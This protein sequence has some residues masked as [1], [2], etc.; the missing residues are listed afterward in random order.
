M[1]QVFA[2]AGLKTLITRET[3]RNGGQIKLYFINGAIIVLLASAVSMLGLIIFVR[4]VGYSRDTAAV[5]MLVSLGIPTY[6]LTVICDA[7]FQATGRIHLSAVAQLPFHIAKVGVATLLLSRGYGLKA[8]I[9][10]LVVS[11]LA[12]LLVEC[13]LLFRHTKIASL[14]YSAGFAL[15]LARAASTFLWIDVLVA[16][17]AGYNVILLSIFATEREV[18][19]YSAAGQLLIPVKLCYLAIA[20]SVFPMMCRSHDLGTSELKLVANRLI[21][22]LLAVVVPTAV[23]LFFL[24]A[25]ALTL[26]YGSRDFGAATPAFQV[27]VWMLIPGAVTSALGY[28]LWAS[29]R[30]SLTLRIVAVGT[31][32]TFVAGFVLVGHFG[33]VGAAI[34]GAIVSIVDLMQHYFYVRR[35]VYRV[36]IHALGWKPV[37]AGLVMALYLSAVHQASPLANGL[38][39]VTT[40]TVALIVLTL[41]SL[42]MSNRVASRNFWL[43]SP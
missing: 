12:I 6:A 39:A 24:A 10:V 28:L 33:V 27:M 20:F 26:L 2:G 1:C 4:V 8:I 18:G 16:L 35:A 22:F 23:A 34:A 21:A 25:P 32:V 29:L 42:A 36:R 19:L 15:S 30:E 43:S 13:W 31:A 11:Q 3:A 14:K 37:V 41:A 5:I 40:Y 17:T 7:I 9:A 38:V